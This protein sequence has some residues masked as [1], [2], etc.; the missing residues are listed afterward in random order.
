MQNSL[1]PNKMS[2]TPATWCCCGRQTRAS[3]K[4]LPLWHWPATGMRV[5]TVHVHAN[6][7]LSR[8]IGIQT[9]TAPAANVANANDNYDSYTTSGC[10]H[11][12][13]TN[14]SPLEQWHRTVRLTSRCASAQPTL[15][16]LFTMFI[17]CAA[18][19]IRPRTTA[20]HFNSGTVQPD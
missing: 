7:W 8:A 9:D 13:A 2:P 18:V 6:C 5:K 4:T 12:T 11:L 3:R 19:L 14:R 16:G 10:A 17:Q 20:C 1:R 15:H